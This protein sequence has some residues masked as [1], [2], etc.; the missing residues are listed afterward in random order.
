MCR[1]VRAAACVP[2]PVCVLFLAAGALTLLFPLSGMH[3]CRA[4]VWMHAWQ[5]NRLLNAKYAPEPRFVA[6]LCREPACVAVRQR[7]VQAPQ[8]CTSPPV[9]VCVCAC[10]CA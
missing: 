7:F 8:L 6:Q 9:R 5:A 10:A 4:M 2:L 1:S 3:A